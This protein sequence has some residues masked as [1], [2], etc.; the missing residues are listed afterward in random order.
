MYDGYLAQGALGAGL[1]PRFSQITLRFLALNRRRQLPRWASDP[2]IAGMT[3]VFV[4]RSGEAWAELAGFRFHCPAGSALACPAGV[5]LGGSV[6]D[7]ERFHCLNLYFEADVDD[8]LSLL[9]AVRAPLVVRGPTAA[10]IAS[11]VERIG[12]LERGRSTTIAVALTGALTQILSALTDAPPE[13]VVYPLAT[14]TSEPQRQ[15]QSA[16]VELVAAANRWISEQ[17][18]GVASPTVTKLADALGTSVSSVVRAFRRVTG[19]SPARYIEQHRIGQAQRSLRYT[20]LAIHI[21]AERSGY[22]DPYHFSRVFKRVTG[23]SPSD[24]REQ[25]L[26]SPNRD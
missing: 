22:E 17:L 15:A 19:T 7:P 18:R 12:E 11:A 6:P 25:A 23:M 24:Y 8:A 20:D 13:D 4:I 1:D 14:T 9:Q 2:H 16:A 5:R 21:V 3:R 10:D 26:T